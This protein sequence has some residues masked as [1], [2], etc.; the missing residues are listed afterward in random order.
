MQV[1]HVEN[2]VKIADAVETMTGNNA[3]HAAPRTGI[4]GDIRDT[5]KALLR[6]L[7]QEKW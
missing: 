5:L 7:F 1:Q 4:L 6:Q 2:Q 3:Q